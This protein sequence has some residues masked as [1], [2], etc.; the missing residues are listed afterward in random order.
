[1]KTHRLKTW[2][3]LWEDVR[4]GRKL[5]EVRSEK[6]RDFSVG[7]TVELDEWDPEAQRPHTGR[8]LCASITYVLH[9]GRFAL[10]SGVCV[11]GLDRVFETYRTIDGDMVPP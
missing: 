2:P 4:S 6:D 11:L 3:S 9:G 8:V 7:D 10:P 1:M 5:F